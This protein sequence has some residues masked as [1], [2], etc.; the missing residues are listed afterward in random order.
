MM[1]KALV[2]SP[3]KPQFVT[4][5]APSLEPGV[6]RYVLKGGGTG[7]YALERDDSFEMAL[8]EGGQ[9]V[10]II[11]FASSGK[12]DL[13]AL[14]LK[15]DAKPDGIQ[16]ILASERQDAARVRFGLF[17]RGL[18]IG[19]AKAARLFGADSPP[20]ECLKLRAERAV[21]VVLGAPA[22][23][24]TVWDQTPS[25]DVLVFI[26]R[27]KPALP[28]HPR[29][30]EPL[31]EP[32]LEVMINVASAESFEVFDGEYIQIIDVAGRQCSDFLAFQR[33]ALDKGK[34]LGL[35]STTT[36]SI[37]GT[38]YP[39]PGL[40]SKFF[41]RDRNALVEV[42]QDTVGRHDTFNLAAYVVL[43][44]WNQPVVAKQQ[45][46]CVL[47]VIEFP[48]VTRAATLF[49][50]KHKSVARIAL[51]NRSFVSLS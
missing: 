5:G 22:E 50:A 26:H 25:T 15:G 16:K 51:N 49:E 38:S 10:E 46:P 33:K 12:S 11:A 13:P 47:Q 28:S 14:G 4:P 31:A 30:P 29:L 1:D 19:R 9:I 7:V 45:K 39:K 35:D 20:G 2:I 34:V 43:R 37:T 27:A 32:R 42:V 17:R 18:D 40:L 23:P 8:I 3:V 48:K 44:A 24:M 6:E 36:R 41:D 21:V